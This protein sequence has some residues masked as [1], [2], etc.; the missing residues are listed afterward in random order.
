MED[1]DERG[2]LG[3][4]VESFREGIVKKYGEW[5]DLWGQMGSNLY[6]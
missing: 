3:I 1:F 6:Y 2:F 5:F 4:Q